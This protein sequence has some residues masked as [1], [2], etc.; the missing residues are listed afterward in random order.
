MG[1]KVRGFEQ[2]GWKRYETSI[3]VIL[4]DTAEVMLV[5]TLTLTPF[6]PTVI[7]LGY[8]Y[9]DWAREQLV[10]KPGPLGA[11]SRDLYRYEIFLNRTPKRDDTAEIINTYLQEGLKITIMN[12]TRTELVLQ[13]PTVLGNMLPLV[14]L[15]TEHTLPQLYFPPDPPPIIYID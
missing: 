14:D 1:L 4:N 13:P 11:D 6:S 3:A 10:I 12:N 15:E 8:W 9:T 5:S 2:L 7:P